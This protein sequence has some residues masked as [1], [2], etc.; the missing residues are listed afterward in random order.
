MDGRGRGRTQFDQLAIVTLSSDS[1]YSEWG[2]PGNTFEEGDGTHARPCSCLLT[3]ILSV[4]VGQTEQSG[5]RRTEA[6][7]VIAAFHASECRSISRS[8]A[9]GGVA[10]DETLKA[11]MYSFCD[12][13]NIQSKSKYSFPLRRRSG[14]V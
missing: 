4:R 6:K 1:S 3:A 14:N 8:S 2:R 7:I 9:A 10:A 11:E 13:S 5:A 12:L